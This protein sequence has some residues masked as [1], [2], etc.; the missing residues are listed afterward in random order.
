MTNDSTADRLTSI[1]FWHENRIKENEMTGRQPSEW[2]THDI[3][4]ILLLI[5]DDIE[6]LHR[7]RIVTGWRRFF[8]WFSWQTANWSAVGYCASCQ[9]TW[10]CQ[11]AITLGM[12][13]SKP[14]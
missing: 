13:D 11:T 10:P 6:R 9:T 4:A 5:I 1:R 12:A 2:V 14:N 3:V 8:N 7:R